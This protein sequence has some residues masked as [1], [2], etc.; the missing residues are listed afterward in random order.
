MKNIKDILGFGEDNYITILGGENANNP[1]LRQWFTER[2]R[3]NQYF[4]WY[5]TS[6]TPLPEVLPYGVNPIKLTWEEVSKRD[7]LLPPYKL[8]EIIDR[9]RGIAPPTSKHAGNI[10]DK[11][12]LDIIVI[13]EKDYLTPYG[14]NHFHLM[15]DSNGNKYT[16]TTTTKKLAT[17]VAYHIDAIIKELKEYKGEQQ[18]ALTRVKV[19]EP[20]D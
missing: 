2:G 12:S 14:I 5:F 9:K 20:T 11:I 6:D 1:A 4:G 3:Y 8:R 19:E 17:N 10:G 18:T 7:E 15:E 13:Y 16:W